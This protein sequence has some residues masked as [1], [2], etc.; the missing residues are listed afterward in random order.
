[1]RTSL[2]SVGLLL[3]AL[4][5]GCV[6]DVPPAD[7]SAVQSPSERSGSGATQPPPVDTP[8]AEDLDSRVYAYDRRPET[9]AR[10][11]AR[12]SQTR[13]DRD[14]IVTTVTF[15]ETPDRISLVVDLAD[16]SELNRVIHERMV[17]SLRPAEHATATEPQFDLS[18][19]SH[20]HSPVYFKKEP[21]LGEISFGANLEPKKLEM[22]VWSSTH[23][24]LLTGRRAGSRRVG[25]Y[26]FEIHASLRERSSGQV[27]WEGRAIAYVERAQAR[28]A[29]PSMV[30]ALIG[31]LGRN[32]RDERFPLK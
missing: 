30:E 24:S 18:F 22:N 32:V 11:K 16:D 4:F 5:M 9:A 13:S 8:G 14:G 27:V 17:R 6:A 3:A 20:F 15:R 19:S 2:V 26:D 1:M 23:D 29:V 7:E 25:Q 31:N 10:G 21:D 28:H 12:D